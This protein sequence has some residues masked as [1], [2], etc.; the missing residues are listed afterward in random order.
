MTKQ[1]WS[2][3]ML[4]RNLF[5]IAIVTLIFS[6]N[7]FGQN[8]KAGK[9]KNIKSK[10]S[11]QTNRTAPK[12]GWADWNGLDPIVKR[13][14]KNKTSRKRPTKPVRN[15]ELDNGGMTTAD[16]SPE[17]GERNAKPKDLVKN[18]P[19]AKP[20]LLEFQIPEKVV[21]DNKHPEIENQRTGGTIKK[22]QSKGFSL[23]GKGTDVNVERVKS[24]RKRKT[25]LR[26]KPKNT[27]NLLPYLEQSNVYRKRKLNKSE[28]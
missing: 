10:T 12:S 22:P 2:K 27:H 15:L 21:T 25:S 3:K 19:E 6:A 28:K 5:I 4:K 7:S 1:I 8:T 17:F 26:K 9:A 20:A 11:A 13:K 23:D 16:E 18:N 14:S 24:P